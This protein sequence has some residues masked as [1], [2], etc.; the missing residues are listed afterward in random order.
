MSTTRAAVQ[1]GAGAIEMHEL[2]VPDRINSDE[3]LV[4]VEGSGICGSDYE[5]YLGHFDGIEGLMKYPVIPG[6][7]PVGRIEQIG[8]EAS[9]RWQVEVGDRVAIESHVPCGVC[10][11]CG[12]GH[13]TICPRKLMY[14]YGELSDGSGLWG[15]FSEY[16]MLRGNTFVHKLPENLSIEDAVMFNPLG[17]GFEWAVRTGGVGVGD[18]VLIF[19]PGQRGL[20]CVIASVMAGANRI[21]VVGL[22]K[23]QAKLELA[24]S[25][26]ATQ[27]ITLDSPDT[28][29]LLDKI[30]GGLF[31]RVVDVTPSSTHP[32]VAAIAAARSGAL[33]TYA[34]V[35]GM[36]AVP[37]FISDTV[38]FKAL[39]IRGVMGVSHDS[40]RMAVRAVVSG[41]F[42]FSGWHTATHKLD[43][44]VDAILRFGAQTVEDSPIHVTVVP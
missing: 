28:D 4:R 13:F 35:K 19:G 42:D 12:R 5:Q 26:G 23:D 43:D 15:G 20:A 41:R 22:G 34:G 6:H 44:V 36:K 33:I 29:E 40:Y 16:M 31:D 30:E 1:L 9:R 27:T 17:A 25:L 8:D 11:H 37:D 21:V 10:V 3:A 38:V 2:P 7:E 24:R 14:G 18:D 32:N 39:T